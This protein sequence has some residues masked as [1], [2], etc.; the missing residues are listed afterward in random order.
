MTNYINLAFSIL[1]TKALDDVEMRKILN[2]AE[3]TF[4]PT[5]VPKATEG[6][7]ALFS[8]WTINQYNKE[9]G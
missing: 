7:T 3:E 6:F 5:K 1:L 9:V 8:E 4:M 2:G